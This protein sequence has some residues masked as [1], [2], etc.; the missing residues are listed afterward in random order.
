MRRE[1]IEIE[2]CRFSAPITRSTLRS[3][4]GFTKIDECNFLG[5]SWFKQNNRMPSI[6]EIMFGILTECKQHLQELDMSG[7]P[8]F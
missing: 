4:A 6:N 1:T 5:F 2:K 7:E 8:E 3:G